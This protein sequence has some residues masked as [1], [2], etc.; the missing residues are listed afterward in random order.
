MRTVREILTLRNCA[1]TGT[2][3]D[4]VFEWFFLAFGDR[5]DEADDE[6]YALTH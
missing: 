3:R 2:T 1:T 6:V 4:E 5:P